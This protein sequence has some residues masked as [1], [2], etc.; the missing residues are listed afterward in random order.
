MIRTDWFQ[1]SE[2]CKSVVRLALARGGAV[3]RHRRRQQGVERK[4]LGL[5]VTE[6]GEFDVRKAWTRSSI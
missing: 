4:G 1:E 2:R 6:C 5:G 3:D